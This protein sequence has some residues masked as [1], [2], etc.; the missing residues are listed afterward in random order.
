MRDEEQLKKA[1]RRCDIVI[2]HLFGNLNDI[3]KL[4]RGIFYIIL[5]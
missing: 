2:C 1:L 4:L 5:F 3:H